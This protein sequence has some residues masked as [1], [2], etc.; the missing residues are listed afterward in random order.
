M[1]LCVCN[2][3]SENA[4]REAACRPECRGVGCV[5]RLLGARVR[6]GRC[7]PYMRALVGETRGPEFP[8]VT[9]GSAAAASDL[10][11]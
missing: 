2:A 6:C 11:G 1:I 10:A 5:Y 4:C 3:L 8:G 7:V 9:T